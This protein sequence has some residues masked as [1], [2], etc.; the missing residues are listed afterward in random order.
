[1]I[2]IQEDNKV[3]VIAAGLSLI[4]Y[5]G[6]S[7]ATVYSSTKAKKEKE[8]LEKFYSDVAST[9]KS[10]DEQLTDVVRNSYHD[11]E[12]LSMLI[13]KVSRKIEREAREIKQEKFKTFFINALIQGVNSSTYQNEEYYLDALDSLSE[14]DIEMLVLLYKQEHAVPVSNIESPFIDDPYIILASINKFRTLGLLEVYTGNMNVGGG[15]DNALAE[16]VKLSKLGR[17]FA[18]FCLS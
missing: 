7:L 8:R 5:V 10:F 11:D 17:N 3:T 2:I 4:P 13:E 15:V 12:Y 6:G 16:S 18:E 14:L 1:M 9:I